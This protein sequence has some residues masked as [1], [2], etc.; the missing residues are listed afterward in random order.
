MRTTTAAGLVLFNSGAIYRLLRKEAEKSGVRWTQ[1]TLLKD[2][3]LLT[4]VTQKE[5]ATVNHLSGPSISVAMN[6]MVDQGLVRR[7]TNPLDRRSA[8][9]SLTNK[10][11]R[12][13]EQ[14]GAK[15]ERCLVPLLSRLSKQ[16]TAALIDAE[17][18]LARVLAP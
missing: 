11:R 2:I 18:A 1:I 15:L 4:P 12:R 3:E 5:L 8:N 17:S 14:D 10:G 7:T 16:E 9:L 6:E 13:L